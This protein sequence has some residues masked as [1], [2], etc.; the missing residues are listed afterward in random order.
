MENQSP[1]APPVSDVTINETRAGKPWVGI[2]LGALV[3]IGGSIA[4]SAVLMF[5]YVFLL[6]KQGVPR[7]EIVQLVQNPES[8]PVVY[9]LGYAIGSLFSLLGGYVCARIVRRKELQ[10]GAVLSVVTV[11]VGIMFLNSASGVLKLL[12]EV[13]LEVALVMGGTW[14]GMRKNRKELP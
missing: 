8:S 10:W 9:W 2:V 5:V 11:L 13:A 7:D 1:Y 12:F 6:A 4:A 14:L 3:D